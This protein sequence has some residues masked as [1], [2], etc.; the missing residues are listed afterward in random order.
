[1]GNAPPHKKH[2]ASRP[3]LHGAFEEILPAV[4]QDQKK[5]ARLRLLRG[6]SAYRTPIRPRRPW[7]RSVC[8]CNPSSLARDGRWLRTAGAFAMGPCLWVSTW[9]TDDHRSTRVARRAMVMKQ[10]INTRRPG[11]S[12]FRISGLKVAPRR[13]SCLD[14][15]PSVQGTGAHDRSALINYIIL[16]YRLIQL[17]KRCT[18]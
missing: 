1:M 18:L 7:R 10:T 12:D 8:R 6:S 2:T 14:N 13:L 11:C 9:I 4:T 3:W 17:P 15:I 5:R 16:R